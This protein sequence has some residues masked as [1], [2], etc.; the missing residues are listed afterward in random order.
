MK[1]TFQKQILPLCLFFF[2]VAS[3]LRAENKTEVLEDRTLQRGSLMRADSEMPHEGLVVK[4]TEAYRR[5]MKGPNGE[6]PLSVRQNARCIAIIPEAVTAAIGIGGMRGSGVGFCHEKGIWAGPAFVTVTA[7]SIG[8]Q[9]GIKSA[10]LVF[11]LSGPNAEH[12]LL[13][14]GY[15]FGGE[16]S[17]VAGKFDA[18]FEMPRNGAVVYSDST[19]VFAGAALTEASMSSDEQRNRQF[20]GPDYDR[21]KV[22]S[23]TSQNLDS[24][25][26]RILKELLPR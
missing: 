4:A 13:D 16:A 23:L 8:A 20:Y 19:G 1:A 15:K 11:F 7:G 3:P 25:S 17:A 12:A 22:F 18:A 5:L 21:S 9:A 10:D 26:L 24:N 14:A 2:A 6:A